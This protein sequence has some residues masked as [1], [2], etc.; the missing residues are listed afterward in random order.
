[1]QHLAAQRPHAATDILLKI[2]TACERT[3][4]WPESGKR[5]DEL[6]SGVRSALVKPYVIFYRHAARQ[7]QI[8]R[9]LHGRRDIARVFQ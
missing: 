9:I 4:D 5:W 6:A 1:V 7:V 3:A 2:R 8:L